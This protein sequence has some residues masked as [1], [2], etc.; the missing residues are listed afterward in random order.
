MTE[1]EYWYWLVNIKGM[2]NGKLKK[3][4]SR[5]ETPEKVYRASRSLLASIEGLTE[6]DIIRI[7]EA[8][9]DTLFL[10]DL[11]MM[12]KK[13]IKFLYRSHEE[14]PRR[15]QHIYNPP[16]VLFVRGELPDEQEP[17][18][19]VIGTR[20][21]THYGRSIAE[22]LSEQLTDYGV[23]IVSGLARGIDSAAH[24]GAIKN[25]G[26]TYAVLGCG[27]DICY[28]RENIELFCNCMKQGGVISEFPLGT[29][30]APW[31][32]PQRNR[33]I[34]GLADLIIVVEA[35]EKSGSFITVESALEQGKDVFAVPGRV[36]D[37]M[38]SG[39]NR[40]I[41]TGAGIVTDVNDI[42]SELGISTRQDN[43]FESKNEFTLEKD[44]QVVY[45][46]L[47]L[48]P[49]SVDQ[50]AEETGYEVTNIIQIIIKLQMMELV[51]EP[52]KNYYAKKI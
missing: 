32:F 28:P 48:L 6:E 22:K 33:I 25:G 15:L 18:V 16:Y 20:G 4:L 31:Q 51:S 38:S 46:C 3:I 36:G 9:K 7:Q 47:D 8:K 39:C 14:F 50:I 2:W 41:K 27:V 21:C 37:V 26:K 23:G 49:K 11:E 43:E 30:P 12:S 29:K 19:A 10:K 34:S 40:L 42:L 52:M 1:E 45:S 5:L 44:L 17:T 24:R 13:G 35:K